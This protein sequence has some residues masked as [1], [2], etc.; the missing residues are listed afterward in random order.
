MHPATF[1][2][3]VRRQVTGMQTLHDE[4]AAG[5]AGHATGA[6]R[7]IPPCQHG[8]PLGSALGLLDVVRIVADDTIR[9]FPGAMTANGS[10]QAITALLGLVV[11][12]LILVI[13]KSESACTPCLKPAAIE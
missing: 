12:F 1:L 11:G 3:D 9:V 13:S 4:H 5:V 7:Q 10:R 2:Q 6:H 8:L